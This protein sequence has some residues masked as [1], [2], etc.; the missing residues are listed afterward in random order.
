MQK[1]AIEWAKNPDGTQGYTW[2]VITGCLGPK[3][4]GVHCPYC[5]ARRLANTRLK[6]RY[7]ANKN[8]DTRTP[9]NYKGYP[10]LDPFYPRFWSDRCNRSDILT[11]GK[12]KGIFVCDMSDLFGIGIP[13]DWTHRVLDRCKDMN[14]HRFYLLTKQ[15]QRLSEF[16]IP[17]NCWVGVTATDILSYYK[18][19]DS[20]DIIGAKIKYISFEP[21]LG[22]IGNPGKEFL[23]G[24]DWVII[25][26]LTGSYQYL[27]EVAH[28]YPN[29]TLTKTK[30]AKWTL[31]PKIE[32]AREIVEAA[33]KA[34][35]PVFQKDNL[36][37][38]L[39]NNL[40]QKMP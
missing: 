9:A 30:G 39:G 4:D 7:L 19:K 33:D 8:W 36:K 18:A 35:V 24:I 31:Q 34:G 37:P 11:G 22:D 27:I 3:G 16:E 10:N 2:N 38:L 32:W 17:D 5:Y 28:K 29:L 6:D 15:P 14:Q 23:T 40:R 13:E 26:A 1:T 25:G 21:L 12:P 20:L